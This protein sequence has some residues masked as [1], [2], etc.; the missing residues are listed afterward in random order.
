[1]CLPHLA[2]KSYISHVNRTNSKNCSCRVIQNVK[3]HISLKA[4][5]LLWTRYKR[6]I[7][8]AGLSPNVMELAHDQTV[9]GCDLPYMVF[10]RFINS[11]GN[12]S[13]YRMSQRYSWSM[14]S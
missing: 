12:L 11:L 2:N 9:C 5:F 10:T 8:N 14:L 6:N 7:Q 3:M 1:M 13:S 4:E